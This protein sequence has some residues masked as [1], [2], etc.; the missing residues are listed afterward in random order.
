M[1]AAVNSN[2]I[3]SQV[4]DGIPARQANKTDPNTG[5]KSLLTPL[6]KKGRPKSAPKLHN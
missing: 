6:P 1:E 4:A 5:H 2:T 3:N